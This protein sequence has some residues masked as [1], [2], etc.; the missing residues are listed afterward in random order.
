MTKN[1]LHKFFDV[2]DYGR[3]FRRVSFIWVL[4]LTTETFM[5]AM[6]YAS[7]P[8]MTQGL[9]KAAMIGAVLGPIAGVQ[10]WVMKIFIENPPNKEE[11]SV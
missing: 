7:G 5:W 10:A 2:L 9:D 11:D 4:W 1:Y 3:V 6:N 8:T